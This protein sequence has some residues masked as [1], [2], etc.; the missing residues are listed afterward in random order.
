M[1]SCVWILS[2]YCLQCG[3]ALW[4]LSDSIPLYGQIIFCCVYTHTHFVHAFLVDGHLGCFHFLATVNKAALNIHVQ[5]FG[6]FF[7]VLFNSFWP[8]LAA[9]GILVP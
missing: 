1:A 5:D 6:G 3:S 8:C 9:C 7:V 4:R 2:V